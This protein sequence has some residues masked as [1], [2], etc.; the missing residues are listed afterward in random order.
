MTRAIETNFKKSEELA[1][2][3]QEEKIFESDL[4]KI[5]TQT[6]QSVKKRPNINSKKGKGVKSASVS[7][8]EKIKF[9]AKGNYFGFIRLG[10]SF[11][12]ATT[13]I[14]V[15]QYVFYSLLYPRARKITN[16]LKVYIVSVEIW[17]SYATLN[18][19]FINTLLWNSTVQFWGTDGLSTYQVMKSHIETNVLPNITESLDYDLGNY[20][21]E[22]RK[23]V[24]QVS[25]LSRSQIFKK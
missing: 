12:I 16:L 24:N 4:G 2:I 14:I 13:M 21:D 1:L 11:A 10:V 23:I 9:T 20:T 15:I 5:F 8:K 3:L 19:I 7:R 22:W 6:P 18:T 17:N 25:F